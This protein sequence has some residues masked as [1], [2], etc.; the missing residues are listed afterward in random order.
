MATVDQ[1]V[2]YESG[3]RYRYAIVAFAAAILLVVSQLLQV[4][5]T[6][7]PVS[8]ATITLI[9]DNSRAT[10]DIIGSVLDMLGLFS[11]AALLFWL[12]R[13]SQ[14]RAPQLR[15]A[16]RWTASTGAVLAAV[17][18]IV[19]TILLTHKAHEFV[20]TGNQ[21]LSAGQPPDQPRR[22]TWRSRCSCW[23]SATCCSRSA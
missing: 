7:A 10:I 23:S 4:S 17:M 15:A 14:A 22:S 8:E 12:H 19:F 21:E 11:L 18:A 6:Q 1:Q 20:T 16:T 2:Q 13:S 3:L 9:T 5:G